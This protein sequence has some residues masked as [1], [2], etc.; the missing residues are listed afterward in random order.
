MLRNQLKKASVRKSQCYID[1]WWRQHC[2]KNGIIVLLTKPY[3][4]NKNEWHDMFEV[5]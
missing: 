2:W 4:N 5:K 3:T 1:C